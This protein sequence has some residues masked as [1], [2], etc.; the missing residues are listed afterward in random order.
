MLSAIH[1]AARHFVGAVERGLGGRGLP[2]RPTILDV[3]GNLLAYSCHLEEI[4]LDEGIFGL[5]GKL[6]IHGRLL[7]KIVIPVHDYPGL[8]SGG[9]LH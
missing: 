3:I 6:P 7:S 8:P 1:R 2:A 5:L 9:Q 4:L